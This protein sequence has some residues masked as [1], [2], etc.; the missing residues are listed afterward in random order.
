[1]GSGRQLVVGEGLTYTVDGV[2]VNAALS[3][4]FRVAER[5]PGIVFCTGGWGNPVREYDF[6]TKTLAEAGFVVLLTSYRGP[7]LPTDDADA[8]GAIDYLSA[9]EFVD[10]DRIGIAG[11][12]RGGM[13]SLRTAAKDPRVK[14]VVALEPPCD[15]VHL[16]ACV[17]ELSPDVHE[18]MTRGGAASDNPEM[19]KALS[20]F[21]AVTFADRIKVPVY[22][23]TGGFDLFAPPDQS[24]RMMEALN[25]GGNQDVTMEIIPQMG[26]FF[27]NRYYGY[28]W[29]I[30]GSA[31]E[32]WFSEKLRG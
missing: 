6:I 15:L 24:R 16:T 9:N 20:Q 22:L 25:R 21:S 2:V 4:P 7:S 3:R 28:L 12:S 26:H 5:L 18:Y 10:P 23:L 17:K 19:E 8:M 29:D 31:V 13:C 32:S 11:H 30:V 27:E 1:M 14:C